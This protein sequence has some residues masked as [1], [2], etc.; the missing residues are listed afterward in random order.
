[1]AKSKINSFKV[2]GSKSIDI[3]SFATDIKLMYEDKSDYKDQLK[4]LTKKLDAIQEKMYA[5]NR[6]G[7]LVIFQAL[8]AAGKDSTIRA[9]FKRV[10]PHGTVFHSFKKPTSNELEHDYMWRCFTKLPERGKIGVFNRSYYEEVLVTKVHPEI[11]TDYQSLPLELTKDLN[12]LFKNRYSDIKNFETYLNNNGIEVVKF[13]LNVSKKEQGKRL[14]DRIK[15]ENK[16]W[17]FEEGDIKARALSDNYLDAFELAINNTSTEASP[18]YVIPADDK[19]NMRLLVA[20]VLHGR[21]K[22]LPVHFPE[23]DENRQTEL[24]KFIN[25]IKEQNLD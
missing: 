25:I 4:S 11:I 7:V 2:D 12:L 22:A 20:E 8:D 15:E 14:I 24:S 16:N 19:Y 6:Y 1:M 17:K 5:H 21:L 9:V 10:N 23:S 3:R 13:F 18:W